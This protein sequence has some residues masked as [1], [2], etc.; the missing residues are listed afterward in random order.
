NL[1]FTEVSGNK[2]GVVSLGATGRNA[3]PGVYDPSTGTWYL[4]GSTSGGPADSVFQF[5]FAGTQAVT[6]DWDGNGSTTVGLWYPNTGTGPTANPITFKFGFPG[7]TAVTGD[8][9]VDGKTHVGI[10]YNGTWYLDRNVN[11]GDSTPVT[12]QFGFAGAIP[13]T[14]KFFGDGKTHV[15]V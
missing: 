12:F 6:G 13:V 1:Y 11:A 14:G 15:G 8:F 2:V 9:F 7:A 3:G 10:Y 4:R 5:G